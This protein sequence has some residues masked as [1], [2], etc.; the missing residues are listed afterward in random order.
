MPNHDPGIYLNE[1]RGHVAHCLETDCEMEYCFNPNRFQ[2][3][4]GE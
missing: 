3:I 2:R 1:I 4:G